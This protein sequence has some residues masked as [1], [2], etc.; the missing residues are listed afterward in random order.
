[1]L[2]NPKV[3]TYASKMEYKI[4]GLSD[5]PCKQ[6][7]YALSSFIRGMPFWNSCSIS[8]LFVD[9]VYT[10]IPCKFY[11]ILTLLHL[12]L[13]SFWNQNED[14]ME[15]EKR[16]LFMNTLPSIRTWGYAIQQIFPASMLENQ[17]NRLTFLLRWY[18]ICRSILLKWILELT[19]NFSIPL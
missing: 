14:R 9:T 4:T 16:S 19:N 13:G 17:R 15:M 8:H 11:N 3:E 7:T 18:I 1:M 12:C 6:Q 5:K 10:C 2:K